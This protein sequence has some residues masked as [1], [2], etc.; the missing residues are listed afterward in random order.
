MSP[1]YAPELLSNMS[2]LPR[3]IPLCGDM[4]VLCGLRE[5]GRG[6]VHYTPNCLTLYIF[7][8]IVYL[9]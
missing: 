6:T 4:S 2:V 9:V 8:R 5:A 3:I 1:R 7:L